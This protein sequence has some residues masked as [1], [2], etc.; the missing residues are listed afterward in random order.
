MCVRVC[1]RARACVFQPLNCSRPGK[2]IADRWNSAVDAPS[3]QA[4][5]PSRLDSTYQ[6]QDRKVF[7]EFPTHAV[8]LLSV[9]NWCLAP[10][11]RASQTD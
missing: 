8:T 11:A 10:V 3:L 1:V 4:C 5:R 2:R 9:I 6:W 7:I